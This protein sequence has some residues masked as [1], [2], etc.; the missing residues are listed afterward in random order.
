MSVTVSSMGKV[1]ISGTS[2]FPDEASPYAKELV[3]KEMARRGADFLRA[4]LLLRDSGGS[5]YVWRHELCVGI[6]LTLKAILLHCDF[7]RYWPRL[8][9]FGHRLVVLADEAAS[10]FGQPT[11]SGELR[12]QLVELGRMYASHRL[13]YSSGRTLFEEPDRLHCERVL[14]RLLAVVRVLGRGSH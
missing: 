10:A 8:T 13:R 4:A 7:D 14:S 6:E 12:T 9:S 1:L 2:S 3:A 11:P 5:P